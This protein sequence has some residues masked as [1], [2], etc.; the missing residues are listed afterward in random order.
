MRVFH[1]KHVLPCLPFLLVLKKYE[2][3]SIRGVVVDYSSLPFL[4]TLKPLFCFG[5]PIYQC[6]KKWDNMSICSVPA[7][8]DNLHICLVRLYWVSDQIRCV[9][10]RKSL[11]ETPKFNVIEIA[12]A[13]IRTCHEECYL[14]LLRETFDCHWK[15]MESWVG[16][17]NVVIWSRL[18]CANS[19]K[20]VFS[21]QGTW[22]SPN[23]LPTMVN[24]QAFRMIAWQSPPLHNRGSS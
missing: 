12:D 14:H 21:V 23:T 6:D 7:K 11:L 4:I 3:Y 1:E 5:N 10:H 13:N 20:E 16:M 18:Q 24:D 2:Y 22:N 15:G 9:P 8:I 19:L 17:R